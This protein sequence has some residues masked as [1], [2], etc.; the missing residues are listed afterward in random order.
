MESIQHLLNT[1]VF[2]FHLQFLRGKGYIISILGS[3]EP[4]AVSSLFSSYPLPSSKHLCSSLSIDH[5][6]SDCMEVWTSGGHPTFQFPAERFWSDPA[7][8]SKVAGLELSARRVR[9]GFT[10]DGCHS[11]STPLGDF[12]SPGIGPTPSH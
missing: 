11:I 10:T 4:T 8:P 6:R 9:Y 2:L 12:D 7:E 3:P 1:S 5:G